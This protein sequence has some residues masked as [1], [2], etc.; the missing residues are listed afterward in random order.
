MSSV[1]L[2]HYRLSP[3]GGYSYLPKMEILTL[4]R[5]SV[6]CWVFRQQLPPRVSPLVH[7]IHA[8]IC[9]AMRQWS[10]KGRWA[11]DCQCADLVGWCGQWEVTRTAVFVFSS[12]VLDAGGQILLVYFIR[13]RDGIHDP[14]VKDIMVEDDILHLLAQCISCDNVP[15]RILTK[16]RIGIPTTVQNTLLMPSR[17]KCVSSCST[18]TP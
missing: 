14:N 12:M 13:E 1:S 11:V 15:F 6:D 18:T 10:L 2:F 3:K 9:D 5:E 7:L 17:F 8:T 16:D 4:I